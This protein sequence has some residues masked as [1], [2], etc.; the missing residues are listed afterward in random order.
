MKQ[1][2]YQ[3]SCICQHTLVHDNKVFA[4]KRVSVK[5]LNVKNQS[6]LQYPTLKINLWFEGT[7][8]SVT[9]SDTPRWM[10]VIKYI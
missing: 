4:F 1:N 8:K 6:V 5:Y 10:A 3:I 7:E 9:L 2:V